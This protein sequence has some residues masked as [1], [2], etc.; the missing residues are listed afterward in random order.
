ML[1]PSELGV[2]EALAAYGGESLRLMP[3]GL[4]PVLEVS[5]DAVVLRV[6]SRECGDCARAR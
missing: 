3:R 2:G 4:A 6:G 1:L 5:R